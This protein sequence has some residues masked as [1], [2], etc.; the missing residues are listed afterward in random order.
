MKIILSILAVIFIS[1]SSLFAQSWDSPRYTFRLKSDNLE[2]KFQEVSGLSSENQVNE[3]RGGN[4]K[5]NSP[6]KMQGIQKYQNVTLKKGIALNSNMN[7]FLTASKLGSTTIELLD[8]QGQVTMAWSLTNASILKTV[9]AVKGNVLE[10]ESLDIT[11]EGLS[12]KK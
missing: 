6:V 11:H 5:V 8:E 10:I 4:S 12:R 7:S 9:K 3:K 1:A 2:L